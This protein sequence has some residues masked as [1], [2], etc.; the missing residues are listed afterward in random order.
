MFFDSSLEEGLWT[1]ECI[2]NGVF[3][4]RSQKMTGQT[5][6][7][8]EWK[9]VSHKSMQVSKTTPF[10]PSN[11][12]VFA[13]FQ[14]NTSLTIRISTRSCYCHCISISATLAV[15][16]Q[17]LWSL[18]YTTSCRT[19]LGICRFVSFWEPPAMYPNI[20]RLATQNP[21]HACLPTAWSLAKRRIPPGS[22]ISS[23]VVTSF[24]PFTLQIVITW[25]FLFFILWSFWFRVLSITDKF[26]FNQFV[27][28]RGNSF[29]SSSPA[30]CNCPV[31]K[32]SFRL[33]L[34][35]DKYWQV[36]VHQ[37][38]LEG[39]SKW[40]DVRDS[41]QVFSCDS[42]SDKHKVCKDVMK[43]RG[44][45]IERTLNPAKMSPPV[46]L[47]ADWWA[48]ARFV[49]T[50]V[51]QQNDAT[52][53]YRIR[54]QNDTFT[55]DD[56]VQ[57]DSVTEIWYRGTNTIL[58]HH[59][60]LTHHALLTHHAVLTYHI[61]LTHHTAPTHD[62]IPVKRILSLQNQDD[63]AKT[64]RQWL[65]TWCTHVRRLQ[66]S[67]QRKAAPFCDKAYQACKHHECTK[68]KMSPEYKF[69]KGVHALRSTN[70]K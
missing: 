3:N 28:T 32:Q 37:S 69:D 19:D 49:V 57:D 63:T 38:F 44:M 64:I 29:A 7:E 9:N 67:V 12:A 16:H 46:K 15:S 1:Q 18:S 59:T 40:V 10:Q 21:C 6:L 30:W 11:I 58:A 31:H 45:S 2:E 14:H 26:D 24:D 36:G 56:S 39:K 51:P 62:W 23:I 27:C 70:A 17:S 13:T 20:S 33:C 50:H 55:K 42:H 25:I 53:W 52:Y 41:N 61:A 5:W 66:A 4:I 34:S 60:V 43:M 8:S 47:L 54:T 68:R 65:I 35:M 48:R 22:H